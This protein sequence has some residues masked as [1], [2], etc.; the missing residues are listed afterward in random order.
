MSSYNLCFIDIMGHRQNP[1]SN[2][3][4]QTSIASYHAVLKR[5]MKID[6]HQLR[7]HRIN[8]LVWRL[9]T[10][11][12]IHYMYNHGRKLNG[13]VFNKRI[14]KIVVNDNSKTKTIPLEHIR[15]HETVLDE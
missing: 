9:T 6:N 12:F 5:W 10:S 15:R 4:T 3:D 14:E 7:G 13:F 8:F 1:H 2:Q 11:V